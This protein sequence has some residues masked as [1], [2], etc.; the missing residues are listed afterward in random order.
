MT[1]TERIQRAKDRDKAAETLAK[2]HRSK[3]LMC[4]KSLNVCFG[5]KTLYGERT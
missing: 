1:L 2:M 3:C 4:G 5:Y